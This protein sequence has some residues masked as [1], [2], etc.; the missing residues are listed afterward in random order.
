MF[1]ESIEWNPNLGL[2]DSVI[3]IL[4]YVLFT[5][6]LSSIPFAFC[7]YCRQVVSSNLSIKLDSK[8]IMTPFLFVFMWDQL[9]WSS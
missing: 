5:N 3:C 6:D 8:S 7:T 9:V 4:G 1:S 2:G